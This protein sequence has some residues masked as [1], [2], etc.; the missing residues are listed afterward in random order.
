ME[1]GRVRGKGVWARRRALGG[2]KHTEEPPWA[3]SEGP[4][5]PPDQ[6]LVVSSIGAGIARLFQVVRPPRYWPVVAL[7]VL[8]ISAGSLVFMIEHGRYRGNPGAH[9]GEAA[10]GTFKSVFLLAMAGGVAWFVAR[11]LHDVPGRRFWLLSG[12]GLVFLGLDDLL[13]IHESFDFAIH[14]LL[15]RSPEDPLTDRIDDVIVALYGLLFLGL[16]V[17]YRR[18]IMFFR[19]MVWM[20]VPAAICFAVMV[21]Y[22]ML[23]GA[24][25]IEESL[26]IG[27]GAFILTAYLAAAMHPAV[28][29]HKPLER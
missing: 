3:W 16:F 27:G 10:L 7:A 15:G 18:H 24:K 28:R 13:R 11:R 23:G 5:E 8:A 19:A 12:I 17:R 14:G 21:K 9:F 22:D 25:H 26:K 20:L 1:I 6:Q 4:A 2:K 29:Y